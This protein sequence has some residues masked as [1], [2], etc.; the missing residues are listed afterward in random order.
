MKRSSLLFVANLEVSLGV[1]VTAEIIAK[2]YY[3]D[4]FEVLYDVGATA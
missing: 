1:L 4:P 2:V 3:A